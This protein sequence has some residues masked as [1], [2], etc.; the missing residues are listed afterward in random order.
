MQRVIGTVR[1]VSR[2]GNSASAEIDYEDPHFPIWIL[3]R[4][5]GPSPQ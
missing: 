3:L 5:W 4:E 2:R 1:K